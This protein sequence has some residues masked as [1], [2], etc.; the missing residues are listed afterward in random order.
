MSSVELIP[1]AYGDIVF[2][3]RQ[4][5]DLDREEIMPLTWSGQPE[6]LAFWSAHLG[7]LSNVALAD[8]K[9]VAA[10]GAYEIMP[11]FWNVW[12][13]STDDWPL[14]AMTVTRTI[15]RKWTP[16][17]FESNAQRMDCWSMDGHDVAHRWLEVLGARREASLENYGATGKTFHCYS[18]TRDQIVR[19]GGKTHVRRTVK[20][21]K[22]SKDTNTGGSDA[23]SAADEG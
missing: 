13:F 16:I 22:D 3:A 8:G 21:S 19:Q 1:A 15:L 10:F 20:S 17:I 4:M 2:I 18:W 7:G 11:Q 9:P 6:D 14:V 5:R 12:M 23:A